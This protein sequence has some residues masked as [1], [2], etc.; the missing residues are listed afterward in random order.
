M[1]LSLTYALI[2]DLFIKEVERLCLTAHT[3]TPCTV[4]TELPHKHPAMKSSEET[5]ILTNGWVTDNELAPAS[6]SAISNRVMGQNYVFRYQVKGRA[7]M[8]S[9]WLPLL[10]LLSASGPFSNCGSDLESKQHSSPTEWTRQRS[11][12]WVRRSSWHLRGKAQG[13]EVYKKEGSPKSPEGAGEGVAR[14]QLRS[15]LQRPPSRLPRAHQRAGAT[16]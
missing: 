9:R 8:V 5:A 10:P 1:N 14:P 13:K 6:T 2:C 15:G 16:E 3:T 4:H 7:R 12:V 11:E